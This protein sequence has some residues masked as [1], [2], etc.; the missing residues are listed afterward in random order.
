MA[1]RCLQDG[2]AFER[3]RQIVEAQGG[4]PSLI[5]DATRLPHAANVQEFKA[6]RRGY[7]L[8]ADAR[9]LGLASNALGAGRKKVTDAVDPA[10]GLRLRTKPGEHVEAGQ[11]L[12]DVHW[13][14]PERLKDALPYIESAFR[15]GD[16]PP[17]PRLLV[18]S[19]LEG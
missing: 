9:P 5:D 13:N 3:F 19:V 15:I 2:S 7:V 8:A 10:V 17:R 14:E 18:H 16:R 4:D 12:C 11:P 6:R 1:Q